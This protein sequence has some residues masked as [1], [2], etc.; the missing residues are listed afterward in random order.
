MKFV[1]TG[2]IDMF[3]A[4]WVPGHNSTNYTKYYSSAPGDVYKVTSYQSA[5]EPYVI[6]RKDGPSW[7]VTIL[8]QEVMVS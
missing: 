4:S 6:F 1:K 2:K 8:N 3:H 7:Y 5:Y